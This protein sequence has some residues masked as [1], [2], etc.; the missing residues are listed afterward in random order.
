M[1]IKLVVGLG[2]PDKK[3][4][5]TRHNL[6]YRVIDE[7]K[8][9]PPHGVR[10]FKPTGYMN[11]SGVSV[12]DIAQKSGFRFDEILVV[13]DD[14]SLPLKQRRIRP[15]GSDG[16]H[17]GLA[18]VL[19]AFNT[20]DIPRLRVGIGPVLDGVDPA[21]FVLQDFSN[22]E[23][24]AVEI[25]I[26]EAAKIVHYIVKDGIEKAMNAFNAKVV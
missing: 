6:G 9:H 18:S 22:S 10:L 11:S 4:A 21:K 26:A 16:G 19:E 7:L 1:P 3:Y 13:C 14:F 12:L 15:S 2:N 8:K 5:M 20:L 17:N 25:S 23:R 24:E